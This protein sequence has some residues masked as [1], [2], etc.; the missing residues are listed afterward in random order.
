MGTRF[1]G[2]FECDA[3]DEF[4]EILLNATK[5]DIRLISSPVGYPARGIQT[6]LLDLVDK[7][8]DQKFSV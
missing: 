2:T 7:K 3:A 4:K 8:K 1:I 6:N 5:D